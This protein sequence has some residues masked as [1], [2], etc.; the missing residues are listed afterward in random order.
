MS[1]ARLGIP[2]GTVLL[3]VISVST[4]ATL[5]RAVSTSANPINLSRPRGERSARS[6]TFY[7]TLLT[8]AG[9]CA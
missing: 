2:T 5:C 8:D 7:R 3:R 4:P 1:H 9:L 6:V